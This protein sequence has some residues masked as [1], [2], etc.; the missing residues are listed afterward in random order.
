MLT[1]AVSMTP[2]SH[3]FKTEKLPQNI[4]MRLYTKRFTDQRSLNYDCTLSKIHEIASL[5]LRNILYSLNF[6]YFCEI[7]IYSKI[8]ED[9]HCA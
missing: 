2:R 6:E 5:S 1:L 9:V 8:L 3:F 7:E 4:F